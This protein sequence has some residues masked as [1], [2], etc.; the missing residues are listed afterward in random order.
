MLVHGDDFATVGP[1]DALEK[2]G[3]TL[4]T[5]TRYRPRWWEAARR[6]RSILACPTCLSNGAMKEFDL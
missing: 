2:L 1:P 4:D 3:L 5:R 6:A